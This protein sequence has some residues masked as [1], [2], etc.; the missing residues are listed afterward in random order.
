MIKVDGDKIIHLTRGDTA[1]ITVSASVSENEN[2][3]FV[4]GDRIIFRVMERKMCENVVLK[5]EYTVSDAGDEG[6]ETVTLTLTA[7]K[8][9][10]GDIIDKPKD[11]WYEVELEHCNVSQTIIGYDE[12]GPKILRLYPEGKES[13]EVSE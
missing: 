12:D 7:E 5:N 3:K 6:I 8:T 13:D 11:Y 9:A 2:Y 1:C 10:F 4:N